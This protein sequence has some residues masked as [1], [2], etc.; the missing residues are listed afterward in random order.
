VVRETCGRQTTG[1]TGHVLLLVFYKRETR[2]G[3]QLTKQM[4]VLETYSIHL[5]AVKCMLHPLLGS[6]PSLPSTKIDSSFNTVSLQ[7]GRKIS[8][9][10][11]C[12]FYSTHT[13]ISTTFNPSFHLSKNDSIIRS[14]CAVRQAQ[15]HHIEH[16][17]TSSR[18]HR[19]LAT[20]RIPSLS[21][22]DVSFSRRETNVHQRQNP[23]R[24]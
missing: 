2:R 11:K 18:V 16:W 20:L 6:K 17:L 8:L 12:H 15:H 1:L 24:P 4:K 19:V 5:L 3:V 14:N 7:M 13:Q 23:T 22:L 21:I 10:C 9:N